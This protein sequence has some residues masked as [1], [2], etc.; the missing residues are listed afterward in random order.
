MNFPS[1]HRYLRTLSFLLL[2]SVFL[3]G[4]CAKKLQ[5]TVINPA[6][7]DTTGIRKVAVGQFKIAKINWIYKLERNGNWKSRER[8]L[9]EAQEQSL[10]NQ[11]RARVISQLATVPY[12][13][14]VYADEFAALEDNA[15]IQDAVAAIGFS[16]EEVDAVL[17]GKVW[18]D[19]IVTDGVEIAKTDLEFKQGGREGSFNY[20]VEILSYW[21]YKSVNGTMAL[22]LKL[23]R[24]FPTDVLSVTFDSRSYSDKVGGK[25][26]DLQT[27]IAQGVYSISSLAAGSGSKEEG[28]DKIE[29]SDLV[30]PNFNQLIANLSESIAAQFSRKVALTLKKVDYSIASGGNKTAAMLIEAGA[31][32]KAIEVLSTALDQA[33]NKQPDDYYNLGLCFEAIGDY[34]L[35]SVSYSDAINLEPGNLLYAQGIGRIDRLK[36]ENRKLRQQLDTKE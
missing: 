13:D 10:S 22:E 14:L 9:T 5:L 26:A 28:D 23:T 6:E 11:I 19:V 16:T 1:S 33:E 7:V 25:P 36:R 32:E 31:Y 24:L 2:L 8:F 12:F 18:V 34:G 29:E 20:T 35:A 21:P 27:K 17:N 30:L 15:T 4:G 3:V